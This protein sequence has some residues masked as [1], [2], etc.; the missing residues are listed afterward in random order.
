MRRRD[1]LAC[2]GGVAVCPMAARAQSTPRIRRVGVLMD[3]P[4]N[5]RTQPRVASFV[6]ALGDLGWDQASG[7]RLEVR[8]GANTTETSRRLAAELLA[9]GP[10]VVLVS[11]SPATTALQQASSTTPIVFALIIDPVGAGFVESLARPGRNLTGFA[12]FEYSIGGKWLEL[13]REIAPQTRRVAVLRDPA[14][15]TGAGQ[16][17]A[18]QALAPSF[19]VELQ[20]VGIG[21]V[22]E[23]ERDLAAFAPGPGDGM[24]VT[25]TPLASVY[26]EQIISLTLKHR[27]PTIFAYRHFATAGG[28]IAYGPDLLD[29]FR[30][31]ASYANRIL[32]GDRPAEL[33]VQ[34][35]TRYELAVN[36]RAAKAFGLDVP[37]TLLAR[38]DDVIE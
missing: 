25:A 14:V 15:V 19:G 24:I 4:Q 2:A 33:P 22:G 11:G 29:P 27:L 5:D 10:E 9:F 8:W 23:F 1:F 21:D 31:A 17:A 6:Q 30:R 35:P 16:F 32:R 34:V 20:P 13:L 7:V 18:I 12:L 36:V 38:A 3:Q 28:L 26:R 37:A